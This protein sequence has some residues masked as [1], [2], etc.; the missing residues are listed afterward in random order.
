MIKAG[1]DAFN[2]KNVLLLQGPVG[3][4]FRRLARDLES[5]GAHVHKVN[6]NGGDWL[7]YPTNAISFRG[8]AD[9]WP[10]FFDQLLIRYS[11]D[12]VMLFGD[13]RPHHR[14]AHEIAQL[15][16]VEIGVFEEGYIR[17]DYIT[18]ELFGTNDNSLLPREMEYYQE[19]EATELPKALEVGQTFSY[20][21]CWAM[22]YYL[23]C[24]LLWPIYWHYQH[25]RPLNLLEGLYWVRA[26][27]RK[28]Y[29]AH[30]ERNVLKNL[31]SN[32]DGNYFL[33][34]LQV[35]N[36]AQIYFHSHFASV[37]DFI[38]STMHSFAMH[39]P[40]ETLLVIK[41][42]P[43]DRGYHDYA[44]CITKFARLN[45]VENRVFYIHDQH[46]PTLFNH[47]R[48]V[49]VVN[50]TV[51]LS[52]LAH[53]LPVKVCG[54]ALYNIS[55]LTFQGAV[56]QF[57]QQAPLHL[58]DQKLYSSFQHYLISR[59]QLNGNFYKRLDIAD[60]HAGILWS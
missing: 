52:A 12:V 21:A 8:I 58:I 47:T 49:V 9:D 5:H 13:C 54:R 48:G 4:F 59:T 45:G 50:S 26:F 55:G 40:N 19:H 36:D 42:H 17:P 41:H 11:I 60:T 14:V 2:G 28:R 15:R 37:K 30:A 7:F 20:A 57:W 3:P 31:L 32:H 43:L 16:G 39:A 44:K 56:N 6:F 10:D 53:A 33:V 18:L 46:L 35:H 25:H 51:G 23:A 1:I 29:Y 34:P 38:H 27:W 24:T 22:L